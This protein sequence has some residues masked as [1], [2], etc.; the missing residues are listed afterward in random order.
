MLLNQL[1]KGVL[2]FILANFIFFLTHHFQRLHLED[3]KLDDPA[4][5]TS[6]NFNQNT[7]M[8]RTKRLK[9]AADI[10]QN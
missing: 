8:E 5:S 10:A 3:I 7:L 6:W 1:V 4:Y 9:Y 2:L